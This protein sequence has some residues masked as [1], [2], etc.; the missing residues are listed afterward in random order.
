[1]VLVE[2]GALGI[3]EQRRLDADLEIAMES[4]QSR[5]NAMLATEGMGPRFPSNFLNA[6]SQVGLVGGTDHSRGK[7]PNHFCLT[8]FVVSGASR[9]SVWEALWNRRTVA[10]AN[11][12]IAIRAELNGMPIGS[13]LVTPAPVVV[14]C[15]LAAADRLRS[16]CLI[17]D[18]EPLEWLPLSGRCAAGRKMVDRLLLLC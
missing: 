14:H 11:G 2:P 15:R 17:R 7:G 10:T 16:V 9:E 3:G 12:K 6:G 8:G 4:M 5:R 13:Q 18:A 1:M